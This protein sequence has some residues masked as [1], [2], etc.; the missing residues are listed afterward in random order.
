MGGC[1]GTGGRD[2]AR[3]T[4][5][6]AGALHT[7]AKASSHGS[8]AKKGEGCSYHWDSR[9][10]LFSRALPGPAFQVGSCFRDPAPFSPSTGP[11]Q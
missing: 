8:L 4:G 11:L 5:K 7:S 6:P 3:D 9:L 2:W 10:K 1:G